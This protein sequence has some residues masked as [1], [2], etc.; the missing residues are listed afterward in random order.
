MRSL[1]ESL[2]DSTDE[3]PITVTKA[4]S[5]NPLGVL[6]SNLLF[7]LV[8]LFHGFRRLAPPY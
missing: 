8:V 2:A 1:G 7:L 4:P 5:I 6:V 3:K